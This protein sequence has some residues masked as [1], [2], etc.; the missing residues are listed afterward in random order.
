[1]PA[2]H[3]KEAESHITAAISGAGDPNSAAAA[4]LATARATL[5]V[6]QQLQVLNAAIQRI[7]QNVLQLAAA[8]N[9]GQR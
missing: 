9:R 6:A 2:D 7:D 3:M 4:Q 8:M 1:M 5:A